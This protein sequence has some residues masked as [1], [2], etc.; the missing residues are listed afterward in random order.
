M[1]ILLKMSL[2]I[3]KHLL[4]FLQIFGGDAEIVQSIQYGHLMQL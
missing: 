4:T 3:S 1:I 2:R